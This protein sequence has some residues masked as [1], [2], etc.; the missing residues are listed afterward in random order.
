LEAGRKIE[1]KNSRYDESNRFYMIPGRTAF[2]NILAD[3][4]KSGKANFAIASES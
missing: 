2:A 3:T 1:E 4:K